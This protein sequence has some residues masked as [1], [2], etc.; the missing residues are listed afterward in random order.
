M[1]R[2]CFPRCPPWFAVW[3]CKHIRAVKVA[4]L[5][6]KPATC[7]RTTPL[8]VQNSRL[9]FCLWGPGCCAFLFSALRDSC[10]FCRRWGQVT[11]TMLSHLTSLGLGDCTPLGSSQRGGE[12]SLCFCSL[13]RVQFY[14]ARRGRA[15]HARGTSPYVRVPPH[16]C[17]GRQL[18]AHL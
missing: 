2:G 5:C 1:G 7:L 3:F 12:S 10:S 15:V 11:V 16:R 17:Q 6:S 8:S 9:C 18:P 4:I 13:T 14:G